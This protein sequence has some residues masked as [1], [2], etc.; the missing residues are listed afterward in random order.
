M[1]ARQL[2][3]LVITGF[4]E[5]KN[6]TVGSLTPKVYLRVGELFRG[7]YG[8]HAGWAHSLLFAA[9][10]PAFRPALNRVAHLRLPDRV[11]L[12]WLS[13]QGLDDLSLSCP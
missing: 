1:L 7:R 12:L 11:E 5:S 6:A 2:P 8:A 10:L 13:A 4:I 3:A 9:E